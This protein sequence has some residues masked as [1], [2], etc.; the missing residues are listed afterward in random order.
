MGSSGIS[1]DFLFVS[2]FEGFGDEGGDSMKA[3]F[4]FISGFVEFE[5]EVKV[6][7]HHP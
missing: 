3:L 1:S 5:S 4:Y 7:G 2:C 6:F